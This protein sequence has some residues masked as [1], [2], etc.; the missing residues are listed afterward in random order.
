[1]QIDLQKTDRG[2]VKKI[3]FS[4]VFDDSVQMFERVKSVKY[5]TLRAIYVI[6]YA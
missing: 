2:F 3:P 6:T 1:M 5:H 4:C